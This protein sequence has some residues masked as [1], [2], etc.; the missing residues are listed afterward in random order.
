MPSPTCALRSP[1]GFVCQVIRLSTR[2]AL[3]NFYCRKLVSSELA[4]SRAS[5]SLRSE[6]DLLRLADGTTFVS[7]IHRQCNRPVRSQTYSGN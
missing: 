1:A 5:Q 2:L 3:R 7:G 6:E 4:S